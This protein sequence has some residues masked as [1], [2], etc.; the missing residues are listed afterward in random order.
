MFQPSMCPIGAVH[1]R[2][3]G[4]PS[5]ARRLG[6]L[7]CVPAVVGFDFS[8]GGSFPVIDGAVVLKQDADKFVKE[9]KRLE[10]TKEERENKTKGKKKKE[11]KDEAGEANQA[12]IDRTVKAQRQVFTHDD[13]MQLKR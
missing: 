9:W 2:L 13:L 7:E 1:L 6:G 5:I 10:A 8:S 11:T 12:V 4:L 3:S